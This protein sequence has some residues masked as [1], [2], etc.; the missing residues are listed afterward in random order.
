MAKAE[1]KSTSKN[2]ARTT[3]LVQTMRRED[4]PRSGLALGGIGTGSF[5]LFKDGCFRNWTIFNNK[6]WGTGSRL[7]DVPDD[8]RTPS[9]YLEDNFLFFTVR[10]C[11][12]GGNPK[13]KVLQ[14]NEPHYVAA[15]E[16]PTY[17]YP[18]MTGVDRIETE[19][20]FPF[21]KMTFHDAEMPFAVELTAFSPFI[22]HD[23]KNSSLPAAL[24]SFRVTGTGK[25]SVDVRIAASMRNCAGY[26]TDEK[27]YATSVVAEDGMRLVEMTM[28]EM[29][30]TQSSFGST[31]LAALGAGASHY[32][33]WEHIHPYY[34]I[35]IRRD[36]LPDIDDTEGRNA[37]NKETGKKRAS[38][39]LWSTVANSAT[40]DKGKGEL[41]TTFLLTWHFPNLYAQATDAEPVREGH[42]YE[43]HFDSSLAV[44][45]YVK[46]NLDDLTTRTRQFHDAFFDSDV[47]D[48]VLAQ[49]NANLNTFVTSSWFT[50]DG[51]Y[52]VLEGLL[53]RDHRGPLATIDVGMY[54]AVSTA[55]LFPDLDKAMMR[56][57]K[58]LRNPETGNVCHGI[59]RNFQIHDVREARGNRLDLASQYAVMS[60]R[61]FFWTGDRRYLEE[62]WPSAKAAIEYVLRER[63][64]NG[65]LLPDMEGIMCSYDNFPMYGAASY[66]ASQFL[67]AVAYAAEAAEAIGDA[68]AAARY[69][70]VL[71]TGRAVFEKKL[72]NGSYYSLYNDDGGPHGDRSEGCLTDQIIGQ[73]ATHHAGLASLLEKKRVRTALKSILKISFRE[74]GLINCKWPED[75]WLHEIPKDIWVDQANTCW[76]GVELAFS[77][78]LIYEGLVK[79]GLEVIKNVDDRY[80]K[81]GLY[82][83]HQEFGGHYYRPMS[84]WANI[85][86]LLGLSIRDGW[87]RFDPRLGEKNVKLFF[88][89]GNGSAH[90]TRT[91]KGAKEQIAISVVTGTLGVRALELGL[92]GGKKKGAPKVAVQTGAGRA[93]P[94][95]YE[96]AA[97][98][99]GVEITFVNEISIGAGETVTLTIG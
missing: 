12:K 92:A 16:Y 6:P 26:D 34:E 27:V 40:F 99:V 90:Y 8:N 62:M 71:E 79:E 45:R 28:T 23:T 9:R 73:W 42:Y 98:P 70:E 53:P 22:P 59:G 1:K 31:S 48:F 89:Y 41:A 76:T 39:R 80:R 86:A 64:M 49:V 68:Q 93:A 51:N 2:K 66:V 46:E 77:S 30:T 83:D 60:L 7:V 72:W 69:A 82:F 96:V 58:R 84:A 4:K 37:T 33:G 63:D 18:W 5:E 15:L 24:F 91:V 75:G 94:G 67:A 87:Y 65:D 47:P 44:A 81:A 50:K 35:F 21:T 74:Y 43:N 95:S 55:A 32:A 54:G 52:G 14:I 3:A 17:I 36:R 57:H 88:S 11:E 85:N 61:G 25:R 29:D 97:T 19:A 20:S 78:F 56:A 13:A 38:A 10:W